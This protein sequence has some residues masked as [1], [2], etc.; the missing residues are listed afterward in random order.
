MPDEQQINP[1]IPFTN[2]RSVKY[3]MLW[4]IA[5]RGDDMAQQDA[6]A[7]WENEL[8]KT[9]R[10]KDYNELITLEMFLFYRLL[11]NVLHIFVSKVP[12]FNEK[13]RF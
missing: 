6:L 2:L 10:K 11:S 8:Y 13:L 1:E 5:S 9:I 4:L 3:I 12:L 7:L